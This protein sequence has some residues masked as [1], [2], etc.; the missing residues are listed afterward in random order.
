MVA[1]NASSEFGLHQ[2]ISVINC[3]L[4]YSA[5][6]MADL[7]DA[8]KE[9]KLCGLIIISERSTTVYNVSGPS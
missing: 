5:A 3:S 6:H 8:A 2:R 4:A 9:M 1:P 7:V